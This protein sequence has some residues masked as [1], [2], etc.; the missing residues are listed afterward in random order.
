MNTIQ[1]LASQLDLF[2]VKY[3]QLK[4]SRRI[5]IIDHQ[6]YNLSKLETP[7]GS[8]LLYCYINKRTSKMKHSI[9][10]ALKILTM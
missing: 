1:C 5:V 9:I 8:P 10:L 7:L 4:I 3:R 2:Q 6:A